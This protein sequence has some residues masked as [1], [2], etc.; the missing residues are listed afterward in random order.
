MRGCGP[1]ADLTMREAEAAG[2][3]QLGES[4]VTR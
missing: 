3:P 1:H 2:M 4:E